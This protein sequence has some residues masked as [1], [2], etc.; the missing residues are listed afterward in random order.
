MNRARILK[1]LL[2][3]IL[4][5]GAARFTHHQT[6]GMRLAKFRG[7]ES[8]LKEQLSPPL[9]K[10][11]RP[12]LEQE[13]HY[14]GRGLQSFSFVSDD[15][16]VVLKLFNNRYQNRLFWL[17]FC[18]HKAAREKRRAYNENKLALTFQ[19]YQLAKERLRDECG[20]LYLHPKRSKESLTVT[21]I[22]KL[23]IRHQMA[24]EKHAFALQKKATLVYP[25]LAKCAE[26]QEFELAK[27]ALKKLVQ[28]LQKKQICGLDDR[29]PLIRTN[30]GFLN[31]EPMQID[32]GPF[33]LAGEEKSPAEQKEAIAKITL[34]L[35]HWL[36]EH[37]K[38]LL[39][40]LDEAL[41]CL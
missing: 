32:L 12:Y 22:D 26:A 34:S 25:Y 8:P 13:F 17:R 40:S 11:L 29:D 21:L 37:H 36:E 2:L 10:E 41:D 14:L 3:P 23:G 7:N 4:A 39:P 24:L 18:P 19:S 31:G 6:E 5:I 15:E 27:E 9:P 28:F 33:S 1:L 20:L 38:E 35:R 16:T 30:L